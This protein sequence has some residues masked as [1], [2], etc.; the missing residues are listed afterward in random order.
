MR[1]QAGCWLAVLISFGVMACGSSTEIPTVAEDPWATPEEE[2]DAGEPDAG[3]DISTFPPCGNGG[4]CN[5][6]NLGGETCQ[7]LGMGEGILAC[8]SVTCT[9]DTSM[10]EGVGGGGGNN[11]GIGVGNGNNG[12]GGSGSG[13]G[14]GS[15]MN[16]GDT[17]QFF[18]GSFF[19][20][21]ADA[22][23]GFFGGSFFGGGDANGD[24]DSEQN[25]DGD[26]Q[27]DGDDEQ[28]GDGDGEQNGDGDGEQNGD[29]DEDPMDAGVGPDAGN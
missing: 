1:R 19:G 29:G 15:P 11:G 16:G 4:M 10:C 6:N 28:N 5:P 9:Y 25:G 14:N 22:G 7:G 3:P 21:G 2:V 26:D 17:P 20:G 13:Q 12:S 18:G 27:G 23:T 24:G 8:D